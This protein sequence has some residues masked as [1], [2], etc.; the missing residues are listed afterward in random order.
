M[1]A[2]SVNEIASLINNQIDSHEKIQGYLLKAEALT[3]VAL[4]GDFL[5]HGRLIVHEYLGALCDIIIE[6]RHFNESVL[7]NLIKNSRQ[8]G[9]L[10]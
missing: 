1:A 2:H 8:N 10:S 3:H 4:G 7:N 9:L 6:S 5:D